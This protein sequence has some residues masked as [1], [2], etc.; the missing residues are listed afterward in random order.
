MSNKSIVAALGCCLA[1]LAPAQT[2]VPDTRPEAVAPPHGNFS[3]NVARPLRYWPDAGDFVI[4]NGPE[5]FNRPLYAMNSG[6]RVDGG[7]L[8]EFS[9][10]LPGRGGNV[11]FGLQ[12]PRGTLWLDRAR[13]IVTRY[14]AGS[15]LYTV[16]DPALGRASLDLVVLPLNDNQGFIVRAGIVGAAP[17]PHQLFFAY[18]GASGASGSR[19]GDIG[20]ERQPV[21]QFFQFQPE[22]CRDNAFSV[23]NATFM[24]RGNKVAVAGVVSEGVTLAL[25]DAAQWEAPEALLA[26]GRPGR[27]AAGLAGPDQHGVRPVRLFRLAIT[28]RRC[29]GGA[30]VRGGRL[31]AGI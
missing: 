4:T 12:T 9:L 26:S 30:G 25:A 27:A 16:R 15:L 2:A 23:T 21:T 24:L 29:V 8:P 11:R 18:G 28:A 5:C 1:P 6:F 31:A 13:Q 14:Q 20:C 7:D 10:Y 22:S 3:N 19:G 17:S